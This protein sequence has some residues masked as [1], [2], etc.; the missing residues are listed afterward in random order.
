MKINEFIKQLKSTETTFLEV[1]YGIKYK[2]QIIL[3]KWFVLN[4]EKEAVIFKRQEVMYKVNMINDTYPIQISIIYHSKSQIITAMAVYLKGI[5][6]YWWFD[7]IFFKRNSK[8][9]EG[10]IWIAQQIRFIKLKRFYSKTL[11]ISFENYKTKKTANIQK[12]CPICG[13]N[14]TKEISMEELDDIL[15]LINFR[16]FLSKEDIIQKMIQWPKN[17]IQLLTEDHCQKCISIDNN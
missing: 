14:Y 12:Q 13:Q 10:I 2:F 6:Q 5:N 9:T 11:K 16:C 17:W 1:D 15:Y 3:G 4:V 8:P 7:D